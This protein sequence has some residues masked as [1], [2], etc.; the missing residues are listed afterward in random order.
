MGGKTEASNRHPRGEPVS[1]GR[2]ETVVSVDGLTKSYGTGS[3]TV[4]AVDQLSFEIEAGTVVGLLGPNGAGKTT[5]I[6]M[7]LGLIQPSD[8][9]ARLCGTDVEKSSEMVYRSV[10]AMLEGARNIYWRLTVRENV[11]FFARLGDEPADPNRVGRIISQVGLES[12]ADTPVNELSRGMKQKAS[13]ACTLVRETPVVFLDEPTLGLDVESSLELR[14]ELRQL[15]T[16]DGRTVLLSS[17]DMQ[18]IEAVCDRVIILNDG[19]ILAND[20]VE[21]LLD[22]FHTQTFRITVRGRLSPDVR[23]ELT[24]RFGATRWAEHGDQHRFETTS[25]RGNEFYALMDVLRESS[26]T[27]VSV[28]TVEPDLEDIFLRI[29]DDGEV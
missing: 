27:F 29:I 17:H 2:S 14:R 24:E 16:R 9:V 23:T 13:L 8:G 1:H 19:E 20:T 26:T 21:N 15:V 10:A 22:V 7:L 4:T 6:K 11:R 5:T 25:V 3:D 28:D 12:K 18:V